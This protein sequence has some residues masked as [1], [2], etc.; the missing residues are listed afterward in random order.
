MAVASFY[1]LL[2][3][4]LSTQKTSENGTDVSPYWLSTVKIHKTGYI[5]VYKVTRVI[6]AVALQSLAMV[7][8]SRWM[9]GLVLLD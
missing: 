1:S 2:I 9:F 7:M 6:V 5:F 3:A 8:S 4:T